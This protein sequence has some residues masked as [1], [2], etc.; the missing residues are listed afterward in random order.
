MHTLLEYEIQS[1]VPFLFFWI[2]VVLVRFSIPTPPP[3]TPVLYH[4]PV[5]MG[6]LEP[7]DIRDFFQDFYMQEPLHIQRVRAH[8]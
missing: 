5:M 8:A 1:D 2:V 4:A 7:M 3:F 6:L